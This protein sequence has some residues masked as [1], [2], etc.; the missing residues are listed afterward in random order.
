MQVDWSSSPVAWGFL[1]WSGTIPREM[2]GKGGGREGKTTHIIADHSWVVY[3]DLHSKIIVQRFYSSGKLSTSGQPASSCQGAICS[4]LTMML[5]PRQPQSFVGTSG[6][7]QSQ[8]VVSPSA[9]AHCLV[10]VR[11]ARS[12]F[13][14]AERCRFSLLAEAL[15]MP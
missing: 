4:P 6:W 9:T 13:V 2:K 1:E 15:V 3:S 10:C 5:Q 14:V 7:F 8:P 11:S 12:G